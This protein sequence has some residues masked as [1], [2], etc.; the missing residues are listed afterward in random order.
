MNGQQALKEEVAPMTEEA[1]FVKTHRYCDAFRTRADRVDEM[2]FDTH[3]SLSLVG[4][5]PP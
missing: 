3:C 5:R 1:I 2:R 4:P